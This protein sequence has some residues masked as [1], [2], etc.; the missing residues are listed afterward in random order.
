[1]RSTCVSPRWGLLVCFL[2]VLAGCGDDDMPMGDAGG[3]CA[4]D[5]EC[6]DGVFCNG[7]ETCGGGTCQ[8]G[9]SPCGEGQGRVCMESV[10]RCRTD[11]DISND[12]DSDGI[13]SVDCGGMD[14]DDGNPAISPERMELCDA[15]GVDEDC[16]P[17]T[18]GDRDRDND[19]FTAASCCNGDN[20]GNDCDDLRSGTNLSGTEICN[21]LDDDC[22]GNVDEGVQVAG[23]RDGDGDGHGDDEAPMMGCE[24]HGR[25]ALNGGDCDDTRPDRFPM[26][27]E[28]C[29][30]VD[31]DCDTTIDEE[32]TVTTFYRD[33][34]G[35][36][37]GRAAGGSTAIC[38]PEP[39]YTFVGG[40][41][42]DEDPLI[43]PGAEERCNGIDD[44]C[45]GEADFSLGVND[46]EDDDRDGFAD[47]ACASD[48]AQDCND[49][50]AD[51]YPG[52]AAR[53]DGLD[54]DCDGAVSTEAEDTAWYVDADADG[55]GDDGEPTI[56][57]CSRPAG[58]TDRAGDCD[59]ADP[60]RS[61]G[62][63]DVCNEIDDDCDTQIDEAGLLT[64][65]YPDIDNDGFGAS[66]A[67][68][69]CVMPE[70]LITN[71][72]DC[73][74]MDMTVFPRAD[75]ICNGVDDD[76]DGRI[77]EGEM[78]TLCPEASGGTVTCS[79]ATRRCEVDLCDEG[80]GDCDEMGM[81]GCEARF[82]DDPM[83][84]GD[85]GIRCASGICAAGL[86]AL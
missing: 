75:E 62:V 64:P 82:A 25:F 57:A 21:G 44:D 71:P 81:T 27:N 60:R 3:P 11:C 6:D 41:C 55:W 45:N 8:V 20:C 65:F 80:F 85:C 63:M 28:V 67:V 47:G 84:C 35:D 43:H 31:N 4:L 26:A 68:L 1:M 38:I 58:H 54:N 33:L 70:G 51:V 76:C 32:T 14:C 24:G 15:A 73:D 56:L 29:D 79:A 2:G 77:D 19:G 42:D 39:G 5:S 23:F 12:A 72:G 48:D 52:A 30:E 40:D 7:V 86:C 36:G 59:D 37:Y 61:P 16:N 18:F 78:D 49:F 74:D 10:G 13:P 22:D 53:C 66:T 17:A 9:I 46:R 34:D 50:D 83:N 69:A